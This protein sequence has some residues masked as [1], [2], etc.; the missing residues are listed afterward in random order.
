MFTDVLPKE[1]WLEKDDVQ[2]RWLNERLPNK[3]QPEGKT[4]HHKEKDGIMELVPFD[5]HNITKHNGGRTKGHWA[6]A[7]RH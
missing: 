1:L 7:P 6:D 2:F 5:I 3:V 4:W